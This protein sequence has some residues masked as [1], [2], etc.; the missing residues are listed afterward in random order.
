M[1]WMAFFARALVFCHEPEPSLCT[2]G[3]TP[4][5]AAYREGAVP[6]ATV[7]EAQRGA[8]EMLAQYIDDIATAAIAAATLRVLTLTPSS[9]ST[10]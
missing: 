7:L 2:A 1:S 6:L 8:R 5:P 9:V 3:L 10:P 4:S